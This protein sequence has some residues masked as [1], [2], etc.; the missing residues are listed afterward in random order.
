M[1]TNDADIRTAHTTLVYPT[2]TL[3]DKFAVREARYVLTNTRDQALAAV[4][5]AER[6]LMGIAESL[7]KKYGIDGKKTRLDEDTLEFKDV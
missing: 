1:E 4:Q 3:E 2:L 5:A 7:G 6:N